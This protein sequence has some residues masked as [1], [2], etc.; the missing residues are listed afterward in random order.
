VHRRF[1]HLAVLDVADV[2]PVRV[3]G[4]LRIQEHEAAIVVTVKRAR[5]VRGGGR[6]A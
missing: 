4:V 2:D 5:V 1:A 3:R 6:L